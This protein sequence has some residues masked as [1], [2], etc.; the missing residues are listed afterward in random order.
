MTVKQVSVKNI[1]MRGR[2]ERAFT[3]YLIWSPPSEY[4]DYLRYEVRTV[5]CERKFN[6]IYFLKFTCKP[7]ETVVVFYE[8]IR[9]R[10]IDPRRII[11]HRTYFKEQRKL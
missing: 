7:Q 5:K 4:A 11:R 3:A 1:E 6:M 10:L 9:R 8:Q 2:I